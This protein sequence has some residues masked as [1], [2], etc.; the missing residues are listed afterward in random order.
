MALGGGLCSACTDAISRVCRRSLWLCV[1]PGA[2][3]SQAASLCVWPWSRDP[4]S[5]RVCASLRP[6]RPP[7]CSGRSALALAPSSAALS[8]VKHKKQRGQ[9]LLGPGR[10]RSPASGPL[11]PPSPSAPGSVSPSPPPS[12]HRARD[13]RGGFPT[14]L[15]RSALA[16]LRKW[17]RAEAERTPREDHGDRGLIAR[18]AEKLQVRA[19]SGGRAGVMSP[20]SP[21]LRASGGVRDSLF[22]PVRVLQDGL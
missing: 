19:P 8:C 17:W 10:K 6:P 14:G 13:R 1:A 2:V 9:G 4:G 15:P 5:P 16:M 20:S 18:A 21:W 22:P 7:R 3:M 11:L 12:P